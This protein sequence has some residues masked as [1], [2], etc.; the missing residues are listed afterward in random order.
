MPASKAH[1]KATTKYES[2]AYDK[3]TFRVRKDGE[4]SKDNITAYA[5]KVGESLNAYIYEAVRQR[6]ER[7]GGT[8]C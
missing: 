2:K 1:I 5:E 7:D 4:L 6:M 3:I 8:T